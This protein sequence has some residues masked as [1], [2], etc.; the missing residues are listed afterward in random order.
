MENSD[1]V[2]DNIINFLT[3]KDAKFEDLQTD[4]VDRI[5]LFQL[6]TFKLHSG[7]ISTFKIECDALTEQDWNTLAW[8]IYSKIRFQ[9]VFGVPT[10]GLRL[11]EV[12][13]KY[14][15]KNEVDPILIVDDVLTTGS[16]I[17]ELRSRYPGSQGFVVF[18]RGPLPKGVRALFTLM[19]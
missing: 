10:G 1:P 14:E 12:L 8:L 11:A 18:A 17:Q 4:G 19:E 9:L 16:S 7:E 5:A 13:R 6:G 15:S 2:A 3:A